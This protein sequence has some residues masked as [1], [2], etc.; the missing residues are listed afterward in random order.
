M[1]RAARAASLPIT[2]TLVAFAGV[3]A[4]RA[5]SGHDP[6]EMAKLYVQS[7]EKIALVVGPYYR[8]PPGM[9]AD[10]VTQFL[11][12]MTLEVHAE[13]EAFGYARAVSSTR[14]VVIIG[15]LHGQLF[16]LIAY[17]K[18]IQNKYSHLEKLPESELLV[19][20]PKLQY[21]FMGDYVD[22]GERSTEM[23][24]L[25]LAYKHLCPSGLILLQ[26]NH[27]SPEMNE[28]Y[29]FGS[30]ILG[31]FTEPKW[32]GQNLDQRRQ[33]AKI[34]W[35]LFNGLFRDLPIVAVAK[36]EFMA[37]HGGL[38]SEFVNACQGVAGDFHKCLT[39]ENGKNTRW[40][41]PFD[42]KEK[43]RESRRGPGIEDFSGQVAYEFL[44]SNGLKRLFRGHTA[45]ANGH[46]LF[47]MRSSVDVKA[48]HTV[49]SAADYV[50]VLC[51]TRNRKPL[52][53]PSWDRHSAKPMLSGPGMNNL[54]GIMFVDHL[55]IGD[56]TYAVQLMRGDDARREALQFTGANCQHPKKI[57]ITWGPSLLE[58]GEEPEEEVEELE[59]EMACFEPL[60]SEEAA[61]HEDFVRETLANASN[62]E[63]E[64]RKIIDMQGEALVCDKDPHEEETVNCKTLARDKITMKVYAEMA[65]SSLEI[66]TGDI[67][68]REAVIEE[69]IRNKEGRGVSRIASS[70]PARID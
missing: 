29:G 14:S 31:K 52:V 24:L 10:R 59:A 35:N 51:I 17:L 12:R 3:H 9:D 64:A 1:W 46:R 50:G 34:V 26:G 23:V 22:R 43:F 30:E 32:H 7:M 62:M 67:D 57:K 70:L 39:W 28:R 19:C 44:E 13:R 53:R 5:E 48:I 42:G 65:N 45:E 63:F 49:F 25:L 60:T 18:Q 6:R 33:K 41:D 37:L 20:D 69:D 11:R 38:T 36:G 47:E 15:D 40:A 4:M 8:E 58:K 21:L 56:A 54:G 61:A 27:E 55:D 66:L 2:V 16:N 68:H